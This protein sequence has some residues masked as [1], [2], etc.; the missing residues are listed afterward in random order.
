[1]DH[2][3]SQAKRLVLKGRFVFPVAGQPIPG[4]AVTVQGTKIVAVGPATAVPEKGDSPHLP[5]RPEG[6]FAQMGTVP[7]F[8]PPEVRDLGNVAILPGLVNAHV[9]L[10]FSD[11]AA[12]LGEARIGLAAWIRQVMD[13]RRRWPGDG[14]R[15]VVLGLAESIRYGVTT[16][17]EIAQPDWLIEAAAAATLNLTVFQELIAPTA[18]RVG[19]RAG[20][21]Q[22]ASSSRCGWHAFE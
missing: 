17:G 9:H 7:F 12:P 6:C 21:G 18:E 16:L 2:R 20:A 3:A 5:E 22:M 8:L 1:M 19:R 11:L 15:S 13:Y 4:G 14:P 10:D